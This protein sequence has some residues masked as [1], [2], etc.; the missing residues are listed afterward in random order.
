[1]LLER[2]KRDRESMNDRDIRAALGAHLH[3]QVAAD[4]L[5]VEELGLCQGDVFVDVAVVDGTIEGYEIKSDRDTLRRLERQLAVYSRV[6]SKATIVVGQK[7][8]EAAKSSVPDWWGILLA[9]PT[10]DRVE[11]GH[12]RR[13]RRNPA[14]DPNSLVQLLW[15]DEALQLLQEQQKAKGLLS[16]PRRVIWERLIEEFSVRE[17]Q[18]TVCSQLKRRADW[19][20][21]SPRIRRGDSYPPEP[22]SRDS[23]RLPTSSGI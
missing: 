16:K 18:A 4:A 14:V 22:T 20:S 5:L 21:A 11:L 6:L 10:S 17:L 7:Y 2:V 1:M 9:R 3:G 15:R 12:V 8:V 19:R 23:R 13:P